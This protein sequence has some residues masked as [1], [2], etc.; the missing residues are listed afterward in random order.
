MR[1]GVRSP[2]APPKRSCTPV[3]HP[4][5]VLVHRRWPCARARRSRCRRDDWRARTPRESLPPRPRLADPGAVG[6]TRRARARPASSS[7]MKSGRLFQFM[8]ILPSTNFFTSERDSPSNVPVSCPRGISGANVLIR[9]SESGLKEMTATGPCAAQARPRRHP[10]V[11]PV[12]R[13]SSPQRRRGR[14][15]PPLQVPPRAWGRSVNSPAVA[16]S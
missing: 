9:P 10:Q 12:C 11:G 13:C 14:V 15:R 7:T 16:A 1:S 8:S 3:G 2:L 5:G 6:A 4:A